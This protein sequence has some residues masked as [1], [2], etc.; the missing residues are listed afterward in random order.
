MSNPLRAAELEQRSGA[1]LA[2]CK[3]AAASKAGQDAELAKAFWTKSEEMLAA[4]LA[5]AGL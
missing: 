1:Y 4:A 2:D 5:Q 3:V